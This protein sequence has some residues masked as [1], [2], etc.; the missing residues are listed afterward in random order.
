MYWESEFNGGTE[1]NYYFMQLSF[2]FFLLT[3]V[4]LGCSNS[5]AYSSKYK[6]GELKVAI[7]TKDVCFYIEKNN[8]KGNYELN[9]FLKENFNKIYTFRGVFEEHYPNLNHCI[10][11]KNRIKDK[12]IYTAV[13]DIGSTNFGND[14]C[15][16][17]EKLGTIQG[18][19]CQKNKN[20]IWQNIKLFF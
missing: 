20:T 15:I 8:L 10:T 4:L 13:L 7:K 12:T 2:N 6:G 3:L 1:L 18:S 16:I 11:F 9:I 5:Q 17:E 19:N 14:F